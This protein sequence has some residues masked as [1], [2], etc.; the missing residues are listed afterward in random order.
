[1]TGLEEDI[2]ELEAELQ[3]AV[4][5]ISRR[6]ADLLDDLTTEELHPRRS[7]IEVRLV[8][9]AWLPSWLVMYK[10]GIH[11]RSVTIPA[12]LPT[13]AKPATLH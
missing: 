6:W 5:E 13:S 4:K 7:D 1:M 12:H 2:A 3:A 10:D 8:A 11:T 9:L